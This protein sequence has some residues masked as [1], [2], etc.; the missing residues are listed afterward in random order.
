MLSQI[1]SLLQSQVEVTVS[2][3]IKGLA[4]LAV[5]CVFLLT[6]YVSAVVALTLFLT[7]HT[8]PWMASAV[9]ALSFALLGGTV[10]LVLA[11][12]QNAEQRRAEA[13]A[14]ARR[15]AQEEILSALTGNSG[16]GRQVAVI[17]AIAGLV[18]SSLLGKGGDDGED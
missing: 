5:L 13:A 6:A 9:V 1:S 12:S 8:E 10:F 11:V 2:R 16:G 18:L 15:E 7:E 14:K 4:T 17:A 3:G